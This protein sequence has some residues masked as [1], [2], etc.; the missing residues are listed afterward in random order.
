MDPIAPSMPEPTQSPYE[1]RWS[2]YDFNGG[3]TIGIEGTD[4]AIVAGDTR[5]STGYSILTRD[6][7][8]LHQL[9]PQCVLASGG[10]QTDV[11]QLHTMLDIKMNM[12]LHDHK[13]SMS[14]TAVAQMLSNTLYQRRFFPYYSFNVLAGLDA[15]GKGAIFSYDAIGS[16]ERTPFSSTG[17]GQKLMIPLMDNLVTFKNRNDTKVVMSAEE[18]VELIKDAFVTAG[19]RDIYTGDAVEIMTITK[20][21]VK[22]ER[23]ELKKD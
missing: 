11:A 7:S 9:T 22:T 19:E 6:K 15:E 8:K 12:Y 2:P 13:E 16:Y 17:S 18:T 1:R 20:E 3:T 4:F 21:G 14:T 23:F 10:C 5:M